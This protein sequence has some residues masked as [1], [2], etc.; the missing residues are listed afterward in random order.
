LVLPPF[1]FQDVVQ[2]ENPLDIFGQALAS[3][4]HSR[5]TLVIP[6]L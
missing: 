6:G 2:E 4:G 1:P 5:E 3:Y